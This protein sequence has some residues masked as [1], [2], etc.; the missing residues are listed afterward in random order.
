MG[1]G[2]FFWVFLVGQGLWYRIP[3]AESSRDQES[4]PSDECGRPLWDPVCAT[5]WYHGPRWHLHYPHQSSSGSRSSGTR[6]CQLWVFTPSP[7]PFPTNPEA[8]EQTPSLTRYVFLS[9]LGMLNLWVHCT[10]PSLHKDPTLS[11]KKSLDPIL[12]F[13]LLLPQPCTYC[14][15]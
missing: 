8:R 6:N 5:G 3:R 11:Q 4:V 7:P 2:S 12:L 15:T 1:S 10:V 9:Q 13:C 14:K